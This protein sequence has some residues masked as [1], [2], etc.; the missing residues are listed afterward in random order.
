MLSREASGP[1]RIVIAEDHPVFRQALGHIVEMHPELKVVGEA[2]DGLDALEQCRSLKPDLVLMDLGMPKM[3]GLEATHAIKREFPHTIVLVLSASVE[4]GSLSDALKAGAAGY[5]LKDAFPHEITEAIRKVLSG[6]SPLNQDLAMQLL[7]QQMNEE[8]N[9]EESSPRMPGSLPE[10]S[11]SSP[12]LSDLLT[13]REIEI[14]ER[15]V[16]GQ[17]NREIA[18]NLSVALATVKNHVHRILSKLEVSDRTQAAVRAIELGLF[19]QSNQE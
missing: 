4:I 1:A 13:P 11:L 9:E 3:D 5:I 15:I 18:R 7:L 16:L 10:R 8:L 17:T 19:S 12:P 2:K 6:E 14:L